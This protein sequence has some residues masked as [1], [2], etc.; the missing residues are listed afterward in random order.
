MRYGT[1]ANVVLF[2]NQTHENTTKN[3]KKHSA[4]KEHIL[5]K[6]FRVTGWV[7]RLVV[8]KLLHVFLHRQKLHLKL[9][10]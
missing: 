5:H 6:C 7:I 1:G 2:S 9:V 10:A 4:E 3:V 8:A